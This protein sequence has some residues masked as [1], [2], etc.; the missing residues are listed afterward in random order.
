MKDLGAALS[1]S[2]NARQVR[3]WHFGRRRIFAWPGEKTCVQE[4]IAV[5]QAD[6]RI[7][8]NFFSMSINP[9]FEARAITCCNP[10]LFGREYVAIVAVKLVNTKLARYWMARTV[11]EDV[12]PTDS[13]K[14]A[15]VNISATQGLIIFTLLIKHRTNKWPN[16]QKHF[17]TVLGIQWREWSTP[18]YRDEATVIQWST[19]K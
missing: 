4:D 19:P 6:G 15:T 18:R 7:D 10:V 14:N 5:T 13:R 9:A 3:R 11:R 12:A 17:Y 2:V 16:R 8:R 1:R